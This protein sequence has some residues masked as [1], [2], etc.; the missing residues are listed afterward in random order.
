[1]LHLSGVSQLP[2]SL[3]DIHLVFPQ[4]VRD[5]MKLPMTLTTI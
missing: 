3:F 1:M 4:N 5:E 2:S